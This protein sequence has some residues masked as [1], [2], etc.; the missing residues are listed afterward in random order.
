MRIPLVIFIAASLILAQYTVSVSAE[1]S[2]SNLPPIEQPLVSE[3]EFAVEVAT[4]L[5][6]S[7]SPEEKA[8]ESSLASIKI[9]PQ[10]GWIS[11]DP[12][13]PDIIA[14]I[15]ESTVKSARAG[16]LNMSEADAARAVNSVSTAMNL[17]IK[18]AGGK[19]TY[20]PNSSS[21]YQ[22]SSA[23]SPPAASEYVDSSELGEY[24]DDNGPPVVTYYSPPW[25]YAYLYDWVPWPFWWGGLDFGG[26]FILAD[27]DGFHHHHR[28]TNH[29]RNANGTVSRVN[30]VTRTTGTA[31]AA[32]TANRS[33]HPAPLGIHRAFALIHQLARVAVSD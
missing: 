4:S 31:T 15:R 3:G 28:F 20:D 11:D 18:F 14:E 8:A 13:T 32:T 12:M 26:F 7:T 30:P 10:N 6:L 5:G 22:T 24:Y 21:G 9:A 1:S 23:V 33:L 19:N 25:D 29:V 27:F 16:G 17:A 2:S